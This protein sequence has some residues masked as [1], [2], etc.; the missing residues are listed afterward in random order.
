MMDKTTRITVYTNLGFL[1]TVTSVVGLF[2][3]YDKNWF[4]ATVVLLTGSL[5]NC[6]RAEII[7]PIIES[8]G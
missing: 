2:C 6:I 7:G 3:V 5:M 1:V 4:W 8:S